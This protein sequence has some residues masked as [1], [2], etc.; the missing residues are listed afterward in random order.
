MEN[1]PRVIV[2]NVVQNM[3][4]NAEKKGNGKKRK[5]KKGRVDATH[6]KTL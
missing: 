3:G 1:L 4:K 5:G 2:Q 6:R